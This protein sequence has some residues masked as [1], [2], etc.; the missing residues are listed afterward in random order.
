MAVV[1][2]SS[3]PR[4]RTARYAAPTLFNHVVSGSEQ[5][6]WNFQ[7][8]YLGGHVIDSQ[9]EFAGLL[10]R[11]VARFR[12]AQNLVDHVGRAREQVRE[13]GP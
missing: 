10:D 9:F 4:R 8:E 11:D 1:W 5:R 3:S 13:L 7:A 12:P 6:G 2:L